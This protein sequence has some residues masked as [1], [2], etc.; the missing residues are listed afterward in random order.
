[1]AAN[2]KRIQI[3][4]YRSKEKDVHFLPEGYQNSITKIQEVRSRK[5]VKKKTWFRLIRF[6]W[7]LGW[8]GNLSYHDWDLE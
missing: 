5:Y 3:Y 1:L 2:W 6:N 8:Q 7:W 4:D